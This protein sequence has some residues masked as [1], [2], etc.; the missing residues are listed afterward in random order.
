MKIFEIRE[1]MDGGPN[2]R[3]FIVD[4]MRAKNAKAAKLYYATK[5]DDV[6]SIMRGGWIQAIEIS[7]EHFDKEMKGLVAQVKRMKSVTQITITENDDHSF[8]TKVR[9]CD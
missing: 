3:G 1:F 2:D 8:S 4:Y 7:Q 6:E 5:V 9:S